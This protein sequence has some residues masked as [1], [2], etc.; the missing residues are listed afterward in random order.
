MSDYQSIFNRT[1]IK[2][3]LTP[4]KEN[5]FMESVHGKLVT[6]A[7]SQSTIS[8]V[9]FDTDDFQLIR[10]SI[11][12]PVYKE[13]LRLRSY[14]TPSDSS[15]VFVEVKKKVKGTVY[16]RRLMLPYHTAMDYLGGE[17][18]QTK[19][20]QVQNEI[21]WFL[22]RYP[23][24]P[25]AFISYDRSSWRGVE[26]PN[27]RI[28]FDRNI[29]FRSDQLELI[30][31]SWGTQVLDPSLSLMEIKLNGAMPLW[32]S[33]SLNDLSIFPTSYSKYGSCY[34]SYL[35]KNTKLVTGGNISA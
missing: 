2:Y 6:D 23:L 17:P 30:Q 20:P 11:E 34:K 8:N 1:E 4:E 18:I 3:M 12:K 16:K 27:L 31:G 19:N 9:Y 24:Q 28:T 22:K 7:F 35:L 32:L 33:H 10:S 26:N 13:K 15:G 29:L 21:D 14:E 5:A 25:K